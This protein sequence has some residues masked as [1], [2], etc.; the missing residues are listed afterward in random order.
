VDRG[1]EAFSVSR[2]VTAMGR[3]DVAVLVLDAGEGITEQ[4]TKIAGLIVKQGRAC[5]LFVNKWDLKGDD[6][7]VRKRFQETMRRRFP[8][9]SWAAVLYGSAIKPDAPAQLLPAIDRTMAA[10]SFR[11][12]TGSLNKFIQSIVADHPL[13]VRK[14]KPTKA[15]RSLFITQVAMK[16]PTF[17]LFVGH[18]EDIP[19]AYLR[20]LENRIREQYG[21]IGTP[22][23]MLVR[24][25]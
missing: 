21:F 12:N 3:S 16:P 13:P 5:V 8:F 14:G 11:V 2:A 9:L 24:P 6:P 1:V 22:I 18:P 25:K 17:A 20:H 10:F 15:S 4:D 7:A 19:K 23:R